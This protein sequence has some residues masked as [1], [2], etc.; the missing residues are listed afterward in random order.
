MTYAEM[1]ERCRA[2]LD[3][4]SG[5]EQR[6]PTS[7]LREYLVDGA[8]LYVARV[9]SA[10]QTFTITQ[11]PGTALYGLDEGCISVDRLM[12]VSD[13]AYYPVRPT[14]ILELDERNPSGWETN[15]GTRAEWYYFVGLNQIGLY[16]KITT[17]TQTYTLHCK[18]DTGSAYPAVL[19]SEPYVPDEDRE[20]LVAYAVARCLAADQKVEEASEEYAKY[21]DTVAAALRRRVSIDQRVGMSRSG[22]QRSGWAR[23]T[24]EVVLP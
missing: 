24:Q 11:L 19:D 8:R 16:P 4:G 13:G 12:W 23:S 22:W 21:A 5:D 3:M 15:T 17:G 18:Y 10:R 6:Y 7:T 1:L 14:T 9:G 20:A 2:S